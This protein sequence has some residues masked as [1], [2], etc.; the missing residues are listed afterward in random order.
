MVA[1]QDSGFIEMVGLSKVLAGA[2]IHLSK[3]SL[4]GS[5]KT[6]KS[7]QSDNSIFRFKGTHLSHS[8]N[9][10]DIKPLLEIDRLVFNLSLIH[11]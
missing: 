11:I 7:L 8:Y 6:L 5:G 2:A 1:R 3:V 9:T 4:F 10:A